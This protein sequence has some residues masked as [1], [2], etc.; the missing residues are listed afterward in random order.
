MLR[1]TQR[2][3]RVLFDRWYRQPIQKLKEVPSGDGAFVALIIGCM[4]YERYATSLL[5][6]N[7]RKANTEAVV[8][9]L[10]TDFGA[11]TETA[12]VFWDMMRSGLAHSGQPK[13]QERGRNSGVGW[14]FNHGFTHPMTL[15]RDAQTGEPVCLLVQPWT[16]ADRVV[17]LWQQR[18][19]LLDA[20]PSF[21]WGKIHTYG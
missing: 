1:S 9:Q 11:D 19:D 21:P 2:D 3:P 4:L 18:P 8:S 16:F 20:C 13:V 5:Q 17:E 12:R 6:A 7:S 15:E 10:A 14:R